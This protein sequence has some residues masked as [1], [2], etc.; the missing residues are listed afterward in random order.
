MLNSAIG[1]GLVGPTWRGVK[2]NKSNFEIYKCNFEIYKCI[3][4]I[5]KCNFEI[6][7]CNFEVYKKWNGVGAK[8]QKVGNP[9]LPTL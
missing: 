3:F 2:L 7:K 9:S 1:K 4:D 8:A 6:Y 5:F